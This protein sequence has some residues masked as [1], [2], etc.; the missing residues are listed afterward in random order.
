MSSRFDSMFMSPEIDRED[1]NLWNLSQNSS[2]DKFFPQ[3]SISFFKSIKKVDSLAGDMNFQISDGI[4]L[5][6][7][8]HSTSR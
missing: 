2:V 1:S 7:F 6:N 3:K 5:L 8:A 4:P